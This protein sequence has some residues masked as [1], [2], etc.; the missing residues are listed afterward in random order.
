M[1]IWYLRIFKWLAPMQVIKPLIQGYLLLS[2]NITLS[3][4]FF[5]GTLRSSDIAMKAMDHRNRWLTSKFKVDFQSQ[6]VRLPAHVKN[7]VVSDPWISGRFHWL[8]FY[9]WYNQRVTNPN[10]RASKN[11]ARCAR[12]IRGSTGWWRTALRWGSHGPV[13]IARWAVFKTPVGWWL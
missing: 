4:H 11:G 12:R 5:H 8:V 3:P 1:N 7:T 13:W 9:S 6:T 10:G 2:C